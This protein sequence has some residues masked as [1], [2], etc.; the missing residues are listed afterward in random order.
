MILRIL[1]LMCLALSAPVVQQP[2]TTL[3]AEMAQR[4]VDA[5]DVKGLFAGSQA[6]V[7]T[8]LRTY[9]DAARTWQLD[10]QL[11]QSDAIKDSELFDY[12][13]L[14]TNAVLACG[15]AMQSQSGARK[16]DEASGSVDVLIKPLEGKSTVGAW[17]IAPACGAIV[18]ADGDDARIRTRADFDRARTLF[19][20][21]TNS[22]RL[23]LQS[24]T[25]SDRQT[26]M[27][28]LAAL[29][30]RAGVGAGA[31][32]EMAKYL[33]RFEPAAVRSRPF[34]TLRLYL[35]TIR[36]AEKAVFAAPLNQ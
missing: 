28:N 30:R 21:F 10:P 36:G 2:A 4:L 19:Q 34:A 20:P 22:A 35:A 27:E 14:R 33:A 25:A 13:L 8:L 23:G 16:L 32:P 29:S 17:S 15:I 18:D 26:A 31:E 5:P 12:F 7:V 6:E 1:S 9:P 11:T 3:S 24:M